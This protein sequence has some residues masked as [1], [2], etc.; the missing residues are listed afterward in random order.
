MAYQKRQS[1]VLEKAQT[2]LRGLQ[3]LDPA[4]DLGN[5]LTLQDYATL[6]ASSGNHLQTYN[7]ALAE[8]DRTRIELDAVEAD[9]SLMS[10]R[11]LSAVAA[12]YGKASQEYEMAG[13]TPLSRAKRSRKVIPATSSTALGESAAPMGAGMN[14][15][16]VNGN[17]MNGA[18]MNGAIA[19]N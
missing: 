11:V 6:I 8:A 9:L 4:M 14:G 13:G 5:G 10:S 1:T 12:M 16:E 15:A 2:R 18:G 19:M 17:R 7:V 3:S